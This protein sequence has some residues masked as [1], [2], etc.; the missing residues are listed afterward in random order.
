M[1][2]NITSQNLVFRHFI[3]NDLEDAISLFTNEAVTKMITGKPTRLEVA[4]EKFEKMLVHNKQAANLGWFHV[5]LKE[6]K[7]FI[8]LGK[9]IRTEKA[10]AEIGYSML[11][12]FWRKGYGT[13]ISYTMVQIAKQAKGLKQ[14]I[15]LIDP[16]NIASKKILASCGF[17]FE[18]KGKW[19]GLP[20]ETYRL[21]IE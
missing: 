10:E 4:E 14:L 19:K 16:N 13:E 3:K 7:N 6:N 20:S 12:Q 9:V 18:S 1:L 8:G 5:S 11:P 15:A 17:Q 21:F 2:S